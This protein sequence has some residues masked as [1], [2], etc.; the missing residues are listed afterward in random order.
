MGNNGK[1][2]GQCIHFS[3]TKCWS[4]LSSTFC[5][6][7]MLISSVSSSLSS[8][9]ACLCCLKHCSFS[10]VSLLTVWTQWVQMKWTLH[11]KSC[12]C[13]RCSCSFSK[14]LG[15]APLSHLIQVR[16]LTYF[17]WKEYVFLQVDQVSGSRISSLLTIF[18]AR[19]SLTSAFISVLINSSSG[20]QLFKC[21]RGAF[22][23]SAFILSTFWMLTFHSSEDLNCCRTFLIC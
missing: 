8:E 11:L 6:M 5:V 16:W 13:C 2:S 15:Q 3:W 22:K 19:P 10:A 18:S 14:Q 12:V 21:T 4:T 1:Y 17:L 7:S 9:V 20:S 23:S